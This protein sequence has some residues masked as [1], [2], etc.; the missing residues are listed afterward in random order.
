MRNFIHHEFG[1]LERDTLPDGS[2]T[3]RTP[4]GKSYPSVT[5]VTGLLSKQSIIE[6]RKRVGAEEANRISGRAARRGTRVHTLCED[7]LRNKEVNPDM[8]DHDIWKAYKPLL[9]RIDNIH[10]LESPLYSDHLQVA[11][12]VDC[13]AEWD[14]KIAVIDFK[15]SARIKTRD[16]I[17]G[18]FM[19]CAAYAVAFEERTKIPV[20]RLV[21]LMAVDNEEPL[22]FIEKRDDWVDEFL[23]LR[24]DYR[25]WKKI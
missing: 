1:K 10:A 5:S 19:Q 17:H 8:F 2:R 20:P 3:Y 16:D 13:V 23:K 14:G 7:F 21:V 22:I 11:G 6:W 24:Q 4:S 12:T 25:N 15:T 18:Y 9:E